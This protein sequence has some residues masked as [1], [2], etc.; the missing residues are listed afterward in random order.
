MSNQVED[1]ENA[2]HVYIP[3]LEQVRKSKKYWLVFHTVL[4]LPDICAAL[5]SVDFRA[6]ARRY[7]GWCD[8]Y[9]GNATLTGDDWYHMRCQVLH[10]GS[11]LADAD[12]RVP[13]QYE[14]FSFIDP[15]TAPSSWHLRVDGDN[16]TV[17]VAQLAD[18]MLG[19]L[20]AWFTDLSRHERAGDSAV[21]RS[22]LPRLVRVQ[23]KVVRTRGETF[24]LEQCSITTSST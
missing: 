12:A 7:V 18:A 15:E 1:L 19:G 17:D 11:S 4:T 6:T 13:S 24:V 3:E 20:R 5:E 21:V 16:L 23:P 14:S 2:F 10:L 9:V 8:R 22:N